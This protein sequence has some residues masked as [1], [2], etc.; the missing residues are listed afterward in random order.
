MENTKSPIRTAVVGL[1]RAGWLIHLADLKGDSRFRIVAGAD[2]DPERRT[3]ME[4]EHSC[5]TFPSL[6]AMLQAADPELVVIATPTGCHFADAEV[7]LGSGRHCVLEKPMAANYEDSG[8][9]ANLARSSR[10]KLFVHHQQVFRSEFRHLRE[11]IDGGLLGRIFHIEVYWSRY[12]RRWDWQTLRKNGGGQ[13]NNHGSHALSLLL[14]LMEGRVSKITAD[15]RNIKDAGDAEDHAFL[16]LRTDRGMTASVTVTS[17]CALSAPRW[18]ILGSRGTLQSDGLHST[19]RYYDPGALGSIKAI[20]GAAVGRAYQTEEIPWKQEVREV[21][22]TPA[23]GSFYDN[24]YDVVRNGLE[25]MVS[26]D[27]ALEVMR[28]IHLAHES[29]RA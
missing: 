13:L 20:D 21:A 16:F 10:G 2:G 27:D 9:L 26:V 23:A 7:V 19:L 17:V 24:V 8:K 29:G 3:E 11:V 18:R 6:A 12:S 1:G 5:P 25:M 14:P 15:L 28:V 4:R 22:A